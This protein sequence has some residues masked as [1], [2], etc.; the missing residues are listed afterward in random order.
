M[1]EWLSG[2]HLVLHKLSL[3][4]STLFERLDSV[5]LKSQIR[6]I[7]PFTV[8]VVI[9]ARIDEIGFGS[10]SIFTRK[11]R[12]LPSFSVSFPINIIYC[13]FFRFTHRIAAILAAKKFDVQSF[14]VGVHNNNLPQRRF[15]EKINLRMKAHLGNVFKTI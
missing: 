4:C 2:Y 12:F 1:H 8:P 9:S 15:H 10:R 13:K 3:N 11:S 6:T 5:V 14:L 7:P